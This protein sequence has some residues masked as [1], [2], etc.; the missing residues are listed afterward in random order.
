MKNYYYQKKI[1]ITGAA[2]GIA[3]D[4]AVVLKDLGAMIALVDIKKIEDNGDLTFQADVSDAKRLKEIRDEILAKWGWVDI[5]IAAAGVGGLNPGRCFSQEMDYKTMA[6]NYFGT[7][8]TLMPFVDSM[9][10]RGSGQLVGIS[11]L[12][13]FRGLPQAASYSASKAAQMTMLESLRLDLKGTGVFVTCIHPGFV[14]T[15]MAAHKDFDMPFKVSARKSSLLILEAIKK[16]KKQF[17]YPW[18]M[19][20]LSQ[21][22]RILPNCIYDFILLKLNPPKAIQP[23]LF[24]ASLDSKLD[25]N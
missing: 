20:W 14:E 16:K 21:L 25:K 13:A 11:S 24:S 15:P 10:K 8:N 22:N 2:S 1:L 17:Y 12:A 9:V 7:V 6:I 18:Q 5:V 3:K 19:S 23:K 4:L